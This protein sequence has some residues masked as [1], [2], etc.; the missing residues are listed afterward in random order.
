MLTGIH[1]SQKPI[2]MNVLRFYVYVFGSIGVIYI[3]NK[4]ISTV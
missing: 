1:K 4:L 2:G 3:G